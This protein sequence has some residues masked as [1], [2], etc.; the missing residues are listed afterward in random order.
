MKAMWPASFAE[1][2]QALPT[3]HVIA[4]FGLK[5]CIKSKNLNLESL[6]QLS[7]EYQSIVIQILSGSIQST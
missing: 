3:W 1:Q 2:C 5:K 4:E 7:R 6:L